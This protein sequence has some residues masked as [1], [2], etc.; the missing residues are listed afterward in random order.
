MHAN[1]HELKSADNRGLAETELNI[2]RLQSLGPDLLVT[3][4][5][6][7]PFNRNLPNLRMLIRVHSRAFAVGLYLR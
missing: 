3:P 5:A 2:R 4:D 7:L 6:A 1:G